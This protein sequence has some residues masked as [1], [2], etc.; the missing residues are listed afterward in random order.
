MT[1]ARHEQH[2]NCFCIAPTIIQQN[3]AVQFTTQ[4]QIVVLL[5]LD[6]ANLHV[7]CHENVDLLVTAHYTS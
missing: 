7:G 1:H 3:K 6:G 2:E 5:E 4:L